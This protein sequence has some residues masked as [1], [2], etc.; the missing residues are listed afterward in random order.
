MFYS[1]LN[2]KQVIQADVWIPQS[3]IWYADVVLDSA[4][5]LSGNAE[6]KVND[7]TLKG[8]IIPYFSGDYVLQSSYKI[9]GGKYG[10]KNVLKSKDYHN[11]AGVKI[12]EILND[13][14][15][16]C[17]ETIVEIDS[18]LTR[19]DSVDFIRRRQSGSR[20]IE[21]I[22]QR[23]LQWWVDYN[24]ETHIGRRPTNVKVSSE[25]DVI[26]Y[27]AM[28][29]YTVIATFNPGNFVPGSVLKSNSLENDFVIRE[30]KIKLT[31][32]KLRIHALG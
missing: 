25:F 28:N 14:A 26:S 22:I 32:D 21:Q 18:S 30:M 13:A 8:T 16:E 12:S 15:R 24:G 10:W 19:L 29:R 7:L 1:E 9:V 3:G 31:S 6:L 23:P 11:D 20:T 4:A 17:G 5:D 2:K 27:S